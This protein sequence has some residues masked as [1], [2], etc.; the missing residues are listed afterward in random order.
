DQLPLLQHTLNRLWLRADADR[1]DPDEPILLRL[2]DYEAI[3]GLRG[4]IDAHA[5]EILAQLGP[6]RLRTAEL[7]FRA[8]TDG[9]SLATAVR[10]PTSLR[11]LVEVCDGNAANVR[12][13]VEAFRAPGVNFLRPDKSIP[14]TD[15]TI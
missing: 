5:E 10:R 15:D 7:V 12:A 2:S 1:R 8:L 6:E 3:G 9:K 14:L 4:A 13:V 11:E